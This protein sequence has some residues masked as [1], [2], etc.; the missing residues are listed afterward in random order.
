MTTP[1]LDADRERMCAEL[2]FERWE[3]IGHFT[4]DGDY[5]GLNLGNYRE[6][7]TQYEKA[8]QLLFTPWQRRTGGVDLLL[9]IADFALR[10]ENA[11][12]AEETLDLLSP[13]A[14]EVAS[15][16]LEAALVKLG[17]LS[18]SPDEQSPE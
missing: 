2:G 15:A 9:G 5:Q 6:A 8:W 7:I 11:Q 17:R 10:S 14:S 18:A 1:S 3:A 12:L 4:I 16:E 13:R